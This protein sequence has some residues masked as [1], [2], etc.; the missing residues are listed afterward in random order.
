MQKNKLWFAIIVSTLG[1]FVDV[2]DI[3]LFTVVRIPSLQ[4]LGL[5]QDEITTAGIFLIDIQLIGM[6]MGGLCWGIL[7]DKRGRL[8]VLFGSITLYSIANILNAFVMNVEQ[9]AILRFLAGFGLAGE[10]G[11]G[12]TLASELMP[13]KTRGYGVMLITTAGA[14]GGI[15]GG[16]VGYFFTWQIAYIIGGLA[17]FALLFL[18]WQVMESILF[19]AVKEGEKVKRGSL[20]L[21]F[22]SKTLRVRYIKCLLVGTPFWIGVGLLMTFSP[23]ISKEMKVQGVITSGWAILFFNFGLGIGDISS[24]LLSQWL[25]SRRKVAMIYLSMA[26][27]AVLQFIFLK[28]PTVFQYYTLCTVLGFSVGYWVIFMMMAAELF[29]T[30]MRATVTVSLPNVVR[31]MVIP[32]S[33][34]MGM[35]KPH[36]GILWSVEIIALVAILVAF[37]MVLTLK[38]TYSADLNFI[39]K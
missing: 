18:R 35:L 14:L 8:S 25:R 29:G 26:F 27:V 1:Y 31:G 21:F 23:E 17:G 34:I 15:T 39:E 37:I 10:F 2:Y 7:G 5:R 38:E 33:L 3:I 19:L 16:I 12:I 22:Q 36:I 32:L 4:A 30:N 24:G 28:Q 9:Y 11:A 13:Q 6:L 20:L